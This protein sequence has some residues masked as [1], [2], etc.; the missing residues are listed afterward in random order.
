VRFL[1]VSQYFWPENFRVN[2][3]ASALH[4]RGHQV[5][6]LTGWPNYPEGKIFPAFRREP[7]AYASFEGAPIVRVPIAARGQGR[8]RLVLNYLSF[9]VSASVLGPL[10]LR[11]REFDVIFVFETSPVTAALP[12]LMMRRLRRIPVLMWILDLWPET[13]SA[14][15]AV[16][17]PTLLAWVG[18]LVSFIYRRCDRI[19][20]QSRSFAPSVERHGGGRARVR[21]FPG[22]A[23][24]VFRGSVHDAAP[25]PE[26]QPFS[27]TFNVVFAGNIGEAQ[28]FPSIL[29][30]VAAL[31]DRPQVRWLILGDGRAAAWVRQEIARR[32]LQERVV[33][34]GRHPLERMPSFFQAA[35]ALLVSLKRDPL[36]A[37][38]V[39]AKVQSYLAA[40]LPIVAMLDG[41]GARVIE[42]A[43]AGLTCPAGEGP[44]LAACVRRLT[45]L[46]AEERAG[47]GLR[48]REYAQREFDRE[49]LIS[50]LEAWAQELA[51]SVQWTALHPE[52]SH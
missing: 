20:V 15:G 36:F 12:A 6:V 10:R 29:D 28:D 45:D 19:L 34:L 4:A 3:L 44:A 22:W 18:R 31:H 7:H 47:M 16:R 50:S 14:V 30:A 8:L 46:P 43:A 35:S 33:L 48:G 5:T 32:K 27:T 9:A 49:R 52:G 1:I 11:G 2:D 25:A 39:P 37:L 23:E 41:E 38:T 42:E 26:L 40:G 17:S 24:P 13:L 51:D 21:Y